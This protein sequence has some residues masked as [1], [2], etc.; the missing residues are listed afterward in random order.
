[1]G[2]HA[3]QAAKTTTFV[4]ASGTGSF[5][6]PNNVYEIEYEIVGAGG[7]GGSGGFDSNA[8]NTAGGGGSGSPGVI[9]TGRLRVL[10][11]QIFS[12]EIGAAGTGGAGISSSGAGNP[13]ANGGN[14]R[15]GGLVAHGGKGGGGGARPGSTS[16]ANGGVAGSTPITASSVYFDGPGRDVGDARA[17]T[18]LGKTYYSDWWRTIVAAL[19]VSGYSSDGT[20]GLP[21]EH[22]GPAISGNNATR[23]G[24]GAAGVSLSSGTGGNGSAGVNAGASSAGGSASGYGASGAGSGGCSGG[25]GSGA[26]GNGAGGYVRVW[27]TA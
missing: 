22:Y 12:Y 15:F 25:T 16:K 7:G 5:T 11:T 27:W 17:L 23:A 13:G 3:D 21:A 9:E 8:A 1:M 24:G 26:G 10:P 19:G 18:V 14:T 20:D 6:V 4:V 2:I